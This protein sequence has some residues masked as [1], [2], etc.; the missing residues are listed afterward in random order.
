MVSKHCP[1]CINVFGSSPVPPKN[2]LLFLV[3]LLNIFVYVCLG[4]DEDGI[5]EDTSSIF[6]NY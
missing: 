3:S 2:G 4:R 6:I 5:Q 1:A